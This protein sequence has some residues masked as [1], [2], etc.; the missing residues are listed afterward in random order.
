MR[1]FTFL[2][3]GPVAGSI[4][5]LSAGGAAAAPIAIVDG[6]T[7]I[8]IT[9]NLGAFCL[10]VS[11][12]GTTG[13]DLG[14]ANPLFSFPVTGGFMDDMGFQRETIVEHAGAGL[15]I[16]DG[17]TTLTFFDFLVDAAAGEI[18]SDVT[19]GTDTERNIGFLTF[20]SVEA[21]GRLGVDFNRQFGFF[22][23]EI[24]GTGGNLGDTGADFGF[25]AL[26]IIDETEVSPVPLPA[27]LPLLAAGL[28]G[29]GLL[30]RRQ[31]RA[32]RT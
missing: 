11:P 13:V 6:L 21:D 29:F 23:D 15:A 18:R 4:L 5:A 3:V 10:T 20:A 12:T 25:A 24:F 1:H 16:S 31:R 8:E 30:G 14:G 27:S 22:L 32:A 26:N 7:E 28:A 17:T 19:D 9:A 2:V